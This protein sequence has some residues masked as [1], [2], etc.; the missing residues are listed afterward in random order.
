[1]RT[2][3]T[4]GEHFPAGFKGIRQQYCRALDGV[5]VGVIAKEFSQSISRFIQFTAN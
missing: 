5:N 4:A 3:V 2:T 1:M